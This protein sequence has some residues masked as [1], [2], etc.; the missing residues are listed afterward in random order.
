MSGIITYSY[1][2]Q[3]DNHLYELEFC[4]PHTARV[5]GSEFI[6]VRST[7][8]ECMDSFIVRDGEIVRSIS[9]LDSSVINADEFKSLLI[10]VFERSPDNAFRHRL[11]A[12][13]HS[14]ST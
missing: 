2:R 11:C 6:H 8:I 1:T 10:Y 5:T 7:T 3:V 13:L 4:T 14:P 9:G 12:A